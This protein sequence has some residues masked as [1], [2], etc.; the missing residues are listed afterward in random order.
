MRLTYLFRCCK[1]SSFVR[2]HVSLQFRGTNLCLAQSLFS[3]VAHGVLLSRPQIPHAFQ[4]RG[5]H[6]TKRKAA[7]DLETVLGDAVLGNDRS[8]LRGSW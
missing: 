7:S 2:L 4:A 3:P 1:F 8:P 6:L 5:G